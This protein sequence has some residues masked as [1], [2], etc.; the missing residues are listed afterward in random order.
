MIAHIIRMDSRV[1]R[2]PWRQVDGDMC[3]PSPGYFLASCD[4]HPSFRVKLIH[5][6]HNRKQVRQ[7]RDRRVSEHTGHLT[8]IEVTKE[9]LWNL[10]RS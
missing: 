4:R 10:T 1:I 8:L 2:A 6:G 5:N 9:E 7:E 3:Q